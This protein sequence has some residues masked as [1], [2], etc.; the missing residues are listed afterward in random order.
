MK[1]LVS[2]ILSIS[3]FLSSASGVTLP[4]NVFAE[5][6]ELDETEYIAESEPTIHT[7]TF[8]TSQLRP[9]DIQDTDEDE[10]YVN[11]RENRMTQRGSILNGN[12][13]L[14]EEMMC[15]TFGD[16]YFKPY[17][18]HKAEE[19]TGD[20]NRLKIIETDLSLPGKNGLDLDIRRRYDNQDY[21][22]CFVSQKVSSYPQSINL[23]SYRRVF[24]FNTSTGSSI[25]I[26]F[27]SEDEMYIYMHEGCY[28]TDMDFNYEF[29]SDC[30][31]GFGVAYLQV[32]DKKA[33]SGILLTY[34]SSVP[35][36]IVDFA[37]KSIYYPTNV[38]LYRPQY[39]V[40]GGWSL[41]MPFTYCIV[42]Y[43]DSYTGSGYKEWHK[44]YSGIFID[45][46]GGVHSF[47]ET[48][49]LYILPTETEF[50]S[51]ISADN[52]DPVKYTRYYLDQQLEDG[53]IYN[54]VAYDYR[55]QLTYYLFSSNDVMNNKRVTRIVQV[56]DDYG[57][58]ITYEYLS[59]SSYTFKIKI[60]DTYGRVIYV[61]N[62]GITYK[63]ETDAQEKSINYQVNILP[64]DSLDNN[65]I[66]KG[67]SVYRLTVTNALGEDTIYDSRPVEVFNM[68]TASNGLY[69]GRSRLSFSNP[70]DHATGYNLERIVYPT[71][72]EK[73]YEYIDLY[74]TYTQGLIMRQV[75]GVKATY[76]KVDGTVV[77]RN[78]F[79]MKMGDTNSGKITTI[80]EVRASDNRHVISTYDLKGR[81]TGYNIQSSAT[82]T[83]LNGATYMYD[84]N[85]N[86]YESY[87][88][89]EGRS[90]PY[91]YTYA[92]RGYV[93]KEQSPKQVITY[94]YNNNFRIPKT[95]TC[96]N[97]KGDIGYTQVNTFVDGHCKVASSVIEDLRGNDLAKTAYAYD[98]SGNLITETRWLA[99]TD[100]NK[101]LNENDSYSV[102]NSATS[103]GDDLL[104]TITDSAND[105]CDADGNNIGTVSVI[106]KYNVYGSPIQQTDSY[107]N[108][109]SIQ[110]DSL[111][112][113]IKYTYPN[114]NT[115]TVSYNTADNQV[116]VTDRDG[117]QYKYTY[118]AMG[119]ETGK[120]I[121]HNNQWKP[122]YT[123]EYDTVAG[124][125]SKYVQYTAKNAGIITTYTYDFLDRPCTEVS[126]SFDSDGS[127]KELYN[128][129]FNYGSDWPYRNTVETTIRDGK[130]AVLKK[131]YSNAGELVSE[132]L[133]HGTNTYTTSYTYDY[134]DRLLTVTDTLGGVVTNTYDLL[135]N[136]MS[137]TDQEKNTVS[138]KYD[139]AGRQI[140]ATDAN[141]NTSYVYYDSLDRQIKAET[142]FDANSFS[143]SK[144]YY[145][146]N[147]QVVKESVK[148]NKPGEAERYSEVEY[149]YDS[150]GNLVSALSE[151]GEED[152]VV[153]Y[154]YTP[155]GKLAS[156]TTGLTSPTQNIAEGAKTSYSYNSYGQL[157]KVTDPLGQDV[158]YT[159]DY[160]GNQLSSCDRNKT[161][162]QSTY[163]PF[164]VVNTTAQNGQDTQ[165]VANTYGSMGN[166]LR[167]T[168]ATNGVT[169][170]TIDY[171][172]DVFGRIVSEYDGDFLK[173]YTYDALSN[174]TSYTLSQNDDV[175]DSISYT[176]DKSGRLTQIHNGDIMTVYTYDKNG[177]VLTKT[178]GDF[179]TEYVYNK[180]NLITGLTNKYDDTS[181]SSYSYGYNLDGNIVS[182]TSADGTAKDYTYDS[183]GRLVNEVHTG[184]L[185]N[186]YTYAYDR[187]GNRSS[188]VANDQATTYE[189]DLNNRLV[190]S[191]TGN[192][193]VYYSYDANGNQILSRSFA[194][195]DGEES[196]LEVSTDVPDFKAYEYD[197]FNRLVRFN[198][199]GNVTTYT[200]HADGL[201]KSKTENNTATSYI[202][203]RGNMVAETTPENTTIYEYDLQGVS[204]RIAGTDSDYY[205]KNSHGD[206][207]G[208]YNGDGTAVSTY[209]Y[210][211]F[212]NQL[213]ENENDTN[214]FRYCGEYFD[215]ETN[216]IYLRNRY[217][218]TSTGRFITEDPIKDG[219]NW[220][221]YC[222][223]NP[224]NSVDPNGLDVYYFANSE[225]MGE[226][227]KD[228]KELERYYDEPVHVLEVDSR[229]AF[230]EE[231]N[232][233]GSWAGKD[234]E[235]S[236]VVINMHGSP[237]GIYP[238]SD[239]GTGSIKASDVEDGTLIPKNVDNILI[240][241]CNSGHFDH[242]YSS[243]ANRL[244]VYNNVESVIASDG[245]VM[246][247]SIFGNYS[248]KG[249]SSF[250]K[251]LWSG[252]KYR[253]NYGFVKYSKNNKGELVWKKLGNKHD[254]TSILEKAGIF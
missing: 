247:R 205:L 251:Y 117:V 218:D 158:T 157:Q 106:N 93:S 113:P 94:T 28:I 254:I 197:L 128:K 54:F 67:K 146:K 200:Y 241:G 96:K 42:D 82:S 212:G 162:T 77:N 98:D 138:Y 29:A 115:S 137:V 72:Y 204:R 210:D 37:P 100:A 228:K 203:D 235:V 101:V 153:R 243:F 116:L 225:F 201:R 121:F 25:D 170:S 149:T 30:G 21:S 104:R 79:S 69:V 173:S 144:T 140:S 23:P 20:T 73:H 53:T 5:N 91:V 189:Y 102:V 232:K 238:H 83:T 174:I 16:Y 209:T 36:R 57:N 41:D 8:P 145:D 206:V 222:G 186:Q 161:V 71:G 64:S 112:R 246:N 147:S 131:Q 215:S 132:A 177:N 14:W 60:T 230:I 171:T 1:K 143:V 211:A 169:D 252:E 7:E 152:S 213:S 193:G 192:D 150:M 181:L 229:Y 160:L 44:D 31:L 242:R 165:T 226:A 185:Q 27:Q 184:A 19:I 86:M 61:T 81:L 194:L 122:E 159:Y 87:V 17:D 142:P 45:I 168:S 48:S 187:F 109:T 120:Y 66:L 183:L 154:T 4:I 196:A 85:D 166:I 74:R 3:L 227:K 190:A 180:G 141:G 58:K 43:V 199:G 219:L 107:G 249:D 11:T 127:V 220:Y 208:L 2:Y 108:I 191:Y 179:T 240:L 236:L 237:Y 172:Y 52:A 97:L 195:T 207:V 62:K 221:V 119:S 130:T 136:L 125:L 46:E 135:G 40:G 33:E 164:G 188:I 250:V 22:A 223:N 151:N 65:S 103:I 231:W 10:T 70:M 155:S 26:A 35:M 18:E 6:T 123:K 133:T 75:Y 68:Y 105:V 129:T 95:I 59:D 245:T 49:H 163:G 182:E 198:S 12:E 139:M 55:T 13:T 167:I 175:K 114:S 63:E 90:V 89:K 176:Y 248:S 253:D 9:E 76:E 38:K 110:Y 202:W 51:R 78:D 99:D 39:N 32:L 24:R 92:R 214:P 111:N 244:L 134:M 84:D 15:S 216:N 124:R 126:K 118:N 80:T 233:M 156:M 234:V 178:S 47:Y 217:Y 34:D 239:G 224:V 88:Y 148:T 50:S 56:K